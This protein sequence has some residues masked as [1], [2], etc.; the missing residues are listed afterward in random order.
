MSTIN[1]ILIGCIIVITL[2]LAGLSFRMFT[3]KRALITNPSDGNSSQRSR[4]G[5]EQGSAAIIPSPPALAEVVGEVSLVDATKTVLI[6]ERETL[7]T[8]RLP[9]YV[10]A[11]VQIENRDSE[12]YTIQVDGKEVILEANSATVLLFDTAGSYPVINQQN[13]TSMGTIAVSDSAQE[14]HEQFLKI[15]EQS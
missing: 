15:L 3:Q 11:P 2:V 6:V 10:N 5:A 9:V 4:S 14:D 13:N 8:G 1:K 7:A 12:A